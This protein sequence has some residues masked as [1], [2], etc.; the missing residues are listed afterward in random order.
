[1]NA[2]ACPSARGSI[3]WHRGGWE[4]SVS[5]QGHR[6]FR[7]LHCPDT[8]EGR[9]Q[10]ETALDELLAEVGIDPATARI[11][12]RDGRCH[13]APVGQRLPF[14]P[15]TT[16]RA[17]R[18]EHEMAKALRVS[19]ATLRRYRTEGLDAY[20]ADRAAIRLGSHPSIVWPDWPT[21]TEGEQP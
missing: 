1:M 5:F 9:R 20:Q 15:L 13:E 21:I 2:N 7:R 17:F 10:A 3:R 12:H 16:S 4:L 19:A 6:V 8:V 14:A 11:P 18:S